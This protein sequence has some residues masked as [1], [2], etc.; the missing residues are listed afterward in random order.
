MDT[1]EGRRR[2]GKHVENPA[3]L[4][5]GVVLLALLREGTSVIFPTAIDRRWIT[6]PQGGR[7]TWICCCQLQPRQKG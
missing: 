5:L 6:G 4:L 1:I 3:L 7:W 2:R